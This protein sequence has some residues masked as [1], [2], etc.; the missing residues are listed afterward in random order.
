MPPKKAVENA[1]K[2]PQSSH[3]TQSHCAAGTPGDISNDIG[4]SVEVSERRTEAG[5]QV[6][7][8][9]KVDA[10]SHVHNE[11]AH[12]DGL[13]DTL[14]P[15]QSPKR[16]RP[17]HK[18]KF[19]NPF[20]HN[21]PEPQL[22]VAQHKAHSEA[23]AQ[24]RNVPEV[25]SSPNGQSLFTQSLVLTVQTESGNV[26]GEDS[27]SLH[28]LP[29]KLTSHMKKP[30]LKSLQSHP[31]LT[32]A[33]LPSKPKSTTHKVPDPAPATRVLVTRPFLVPINTE[34]STA[35]SSATPDPSRFSTPISSTS[36]LAQN[37][38][39]LSA[40]VSPISLKS[41][42]LSK[43]SRVVTDKL[44]SLEG[45]MTKLLAT[46][47][48]LQ[49]SLNDTIKHNRKILTENIALAK[50]NAQLVGQVTELQEQAESQSKMLASIETMLDGLKANGGTG[51]EA[52]VKIE[53]TTRNNT[54][55]VSQIYMYLIDMAFSPSIE[56]GTCKTFLRFMGITNQ[57]QIKN[58]VPLDEDEYYIADP[59]TGNNLLQPNW[60]RNYSNNSA[61]HD[62]A[63]E[64]LLKKGPSIHIALTKPILAT[65][66]NDELLKRNAAIF[67]NFASVYK[68]AGTDPETQAALKA[69]KRVGRQRGRKN[70]VRI[71]YA[72]DRP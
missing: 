33:P 40:T 70:T 54:F 47:L 11:I 37:D 14:K 15:A 72:P 9:R 3:S 12:S 42:V 32:L 28:A 61:W 44:S 59:E 64:F 4:Q 21:I 43:P 13:T 69:T 22:S 55:N 39:F 17:T 10:A 18:E 30:S 35:R 63:V 31:V 71:L 23:L 34:V 67:K 51:G 6:G 25:A 1:S 68:K 66:T 36:T 7:K 41:N 16:L 65:Y 56:T 24:S 2:L 46:V 52:A 50:T 20:T 8:K 27:E 5:K 38:P 57:K 19:L 53:K 45:R 26:P 29:P 48:T 60:H 58:L 49:G 62:E